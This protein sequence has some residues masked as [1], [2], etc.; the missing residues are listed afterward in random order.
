MQSNLCQT[1]NGVHLQKCLLWKS[2]C[3]SELPAKKDWYQLVVWSSLEKHLIVYKESN[4]KVVTLITL[5]DYFT[6]KIK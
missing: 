5:S 6:N 2:V 1:Q 4:N 3:I